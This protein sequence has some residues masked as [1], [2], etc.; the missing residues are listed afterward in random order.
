MAAVSRSSVVRTPDCLLDERREHWSQAVLL[1]C[2]RDYVD[3]VVA[4][5][6]RVEIDLVARRVCCHTGIRPR[7]K[8]VLDRGENRTPEPGVLGPER[9][10]CGKRRHRVASSTD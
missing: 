4:R 6:P 7:G 1:M 2:R 9:S 5:E 10:G 3:R 8:D